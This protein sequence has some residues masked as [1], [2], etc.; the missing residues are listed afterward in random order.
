MQVAASA[1]APSRFWIGAI[2]EYDIYVKTISIE[3]ADASA[4]LNKFGNITA[5]TNGCKLEWITQDIGTTTIDDAL[6]TNWNFVRMCAG[7]PAFGDAAGAFRASNVSG[8]SEGY[9]PVMDMARVFGNP[10]GLPLRKGTT[11]RIEFTIQDNT[12][13]V[14][15]FN[16]IGFGTKVI[17]PE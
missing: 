3:I 8:T 13:G 17:R 10:W 1:A 7:S 2:Q 9:I 12:T 16:A 5:L 15:S 14:D 11:D 4:T 6:K